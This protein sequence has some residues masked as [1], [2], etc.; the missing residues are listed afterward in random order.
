MSGFCVSLRGFA[1]RFETIALPIDDEGRGLLFFD[2]RCWLGTEGR[3]AVK[4]VEVFFPTS[5]G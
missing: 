3:A 2:G 4:I 1:G 5:I